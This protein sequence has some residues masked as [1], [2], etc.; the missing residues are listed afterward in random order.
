MRTLEPAVQDPRVLSIQEERGSRFQQTRDGS[1]GARGSRSFHPRSQS[2]TILRRR[3]AAP[4]ATPG[5]GQT[6]GS[7]G[8]PC[9]PAAPRRSH[10]A[11][12]APRL[13][14]EA[15]PGEPLEDRG[16]RESRW[17][18][19]GRSHS[20]GPAASR[21]RSA[22]RAAAARAPSSRAQRAGRRPAPA[23][24]VPSACSS[25]SS[26]MGRAQSVAETPRLGLSAHRASS[27]CRPAA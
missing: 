12:S 6:D 26:T 21:S 14:R 13:A 2:V 16:R 3:F 20:Q 18:W 19:E 9:G 4:Q 5:H 17:S 10:P 22:A 7:P 27:S 25:A 15:Q 23:A 8:Q 1:K 24:S 11:L